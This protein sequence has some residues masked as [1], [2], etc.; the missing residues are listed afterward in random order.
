L[1]RQRAYYTIDEYLNNIRSVLRKYSLCANIK[2]ELQSL[3]EEEIF[4][5]GLHREV[6]I[7]MR[8]LGHVT[9]EEMAKCI[10]IV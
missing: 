10:R 8:K 1:L 2:P 7:E 4:I 3:K 6:L 5:R 9:V